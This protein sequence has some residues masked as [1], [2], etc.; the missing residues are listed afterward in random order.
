MAVVTRDTDLDQYVAAAP[1]GVARSAWLWID[2]AAHRVRKSLHC[3]KA[4]A[5]TAPRC[6]TG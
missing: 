1:A 6:M 5:D 2:L 3:L 4:C